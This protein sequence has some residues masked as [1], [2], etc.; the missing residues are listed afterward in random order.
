VNLTR[1]TRR[2][3]AVCAGSALA[4]TKRGPVFEH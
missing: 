3:L 2:S 4:Q 1:E